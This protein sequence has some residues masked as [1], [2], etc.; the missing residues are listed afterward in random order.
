MHYNLENMME[1]VDEQIPFAI[2]DILDEPGHRDH[3]AVIN[4]AMQCPCFDWDVLA[5]L[6][7]AYISPISKYYGSD[8]VKEPFSMHLEYALNDL[9]PEG[10][11]SLKTTNHHSPPDTAFAVDTLGPVLFYARESRTECSFLAWIDD[12]LSPLV[13][14]MA[15]GVIGRGF[16]TPNHRWEVCGALSLAMKLFPDLQAA[17]YIESILAEGIDQNEDGQFTERSVGIY[18]SVSDRGLMNTAMFFDKPELLDAVRKNLD[19]M[20][21][22]F[23]HD[24]SVVTTFSGR[25]DQGKRQIPSGIAVPFLVMGDCDDNEQWLAYADMVFERAKPEKGVGKMLHPLLLFPQLRERAQSKALLN[26]SYTKYFPASGLWR[27]REDK[28]SAAVGIDNVKFFSMIF[29]EAELNSVKVAVPYFGGAQL[30]ADRMK[31]IE[32]G[33]LLEDDDCNPVHRPEYRL[34]LASPVTSE[35]YGELDKTREKWLLPNPAMAAEVIEVENGFDIKVQLKGGLPKLCGQFECSFVG[36]GHWETESG[37]IE[38]EN[39]NSAILL[40]GNGTF[41]KD[42]YGI[43]IGSGS[44]AHRMWTM[45]GTDPEPG[46]RVVVPFYVDQEPVLKIRYGIW[47]YASRKIV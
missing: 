22:L 19:M 2:A 3:G 42:Q 17:D 47:S 45:R 26:A 36:S 44:T 20:T 9:S 16:H 32:G 27:K 14:T 7:I 23:H 29:G 15:N 40:N 18:N 13:K 4:N 24:G 35:N 43:S 1:I 12:Q 6:A 10:L 5:K 33:V 8:E 46:F 28:L 38:T 37:V 30:N 34:P 31:E 41:Y 21:Y 11:A 39:G 25:Q